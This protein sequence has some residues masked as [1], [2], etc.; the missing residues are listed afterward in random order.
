M[1]LR[2]IYII[3]IATFLALAGSED[4]FAQAMYPAKPI[5]AVVP[6]LAGGSVDTL[7]RIVTPKLSDVW[8]RPIIVENKAGAGGNIGADSVAKADPD[9]YTVLFTPSGPLSLNMYLYENMPFDP[10]T[11]LAPASVLALMPNMLLVGPA[12]QA[13]DITEFIAQIK[14]NPSAI[15]YGSL[16]TATVSHLAAEAFANAINARM[17]HVPYKGFPPLLVDLL[18]GR[19][20]FAFFDAT[21]ALPQIRKGAVRPLAVAHPK[22]F[23]ALP[24]VPTFEE[25]GVPNLIAPTSVTLVFPAGTPKD[26]MAIWR[27]ELRTITKLP[28]VREKFD[29]LGAEVWVSSE[30]EAVRYLREERQRWGDVIKKAGIQK[31]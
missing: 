15:S 13:K 20:H 1:T 4:A 7:V 31:K 17:V 3:A 12:V 18:G 25:A 29:T 9:G 6:F 19:L 8:G 26:I 14:S 22:R 10:Q 30:E 11:A 2:P 24:D 27:N 21:N 5:K 23:A 28:E 16:G